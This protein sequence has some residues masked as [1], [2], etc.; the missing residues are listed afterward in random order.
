VKVPNKNA[1][2]IEALI[3]YEAVSG[4]DMSEY[5]DGASGVILAAQEK[6][7]P[8]AGATVHT[9]T[10]H[11]KLSI[12]IYTARSICGLMRMYERHPEDKWLL[13]VDRG[14]TFLR[15]LYTPQG[16]YFG[17]Y[18]DGSLIAN[19]RCI[20][21]S[22]DLLRAMAWGRVYGLSSDSDVYGLVEV[23]VRSQLPSGG[24]PTSYGISRRGDRHEY[25]GLPEFRDVL[26]VV[27]WCDKALRSLS[28]IISPHVDVNKEVNSTTEI[29]CS[30]KGKPCTYIESKDEIWLKQKSTEIDLYRWRKGKTWTDIYLL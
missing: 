19:P 9:G 23:L 29:A 27:G 28:L 21:G 15:G 30:W 3:T 1:T 17:R 2:T 14:L 18:A 5:L 24:I 7:G 25:K 8:R 13:P 20:A 26:P 11:H 10:G 6:T 4:L 12:G 22:G 16:T